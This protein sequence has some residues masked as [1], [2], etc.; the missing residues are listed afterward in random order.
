MT[1]RTGNHHG[2]TIVSEFD[3]YCPDRN[4]HDCTRGHLAAVVVDGD[5]ALAERICVLLNGEQEQP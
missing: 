3:G 1:Y 4:G 2:V 5:Q